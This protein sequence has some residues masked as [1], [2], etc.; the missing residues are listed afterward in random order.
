MS[1]DRARTA[2]C[3]SAILGQCFSFLHGTPERMLTA[4]SF[5]GYLVTCFRKAGLPKLNNNKSIT[6]MDVADLDD[7]QLSR[8]WV[9]WARDE[10]WKR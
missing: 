9:E 3:L 1:T 2:V 7:N 5:H 8:K 6:Y 10:S 4:E